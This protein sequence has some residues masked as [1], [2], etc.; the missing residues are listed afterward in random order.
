M[1]GFSGGRAKPMLFLLISLLLFYP[2][3][4]RLFIISLFENLMVIGLSIS[5]EE[6]TACQRLREISV[7]LV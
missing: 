5:Y 3:D 6:V 2:P 4:I 1:Y 7:I